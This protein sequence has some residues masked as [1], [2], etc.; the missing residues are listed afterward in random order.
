MP[1]ISS[2]LLSL[3]ALSPAAQSDAASPDFDREV[4]PILA[5][6]CFACHGPDKEGR[7]GKLR[8][9][10]REKAG[11]VSGM[12]SV[13]VA[14]DRED[15]ELWYRITTEYGDDRMPPPDHAKSLTAEEIE[16]LGKW[17][18]AG[19]PWAEHWAFVSPVKPGAPA[20]A[21]REWARDG[22]DHFVMAALERDGLKPNHEASKNKWLRRVT[23]ALTGLPPTEQELRDFL[24]DPSADA[25]GKVVDRLFASPAY[26]EHMAAA[27]LDG[28]RYADT[29]GYQ[30]DFHRAQ[31]PWRDWVVRAFN[32]NL[33]FD[34][35][36]TWQLAGDLLPNASDE[37]VLATGFGRNHRTVTEAG[38]IDEEWRV[39]NV[40]DR[41][42]TTATVFMGLTMGCARCHDHR[43]DPITQ[44]EFYQFYGFFN[45][46]DEKGV[47]QETRGNA[48]PMVRVPSAEDEKKLKRIQ[49]ELK[50]AKER[51][52]AVIAQRDDQFADW[53]DMLSK[54]SLS[55]DMAWLD[56]V[57]L[58]KNEDPRPNYGNEVFSPEHDQAFFM[59][60]WVRPR[61]DGTVIGKMDAEAAYRGIDLTLI[62]NRKISVHLIHN[63]PS[64]AVKVVSHEALEDGVW[65]HVGVSY[66]G[67]GKAAGVQLFLNGKAVGARVAADSL[68]GS[69][70]T[71]TPLRLG[72]RSTREHLRGDIHGA[73]FEFESAT[74]DK[75]G[76][77]VRADAQALW[78]ALQSKPA[79]AQVEGEKPASS[80][81]KEEDLKQIFA[82]CFHPASRES[83]NKVQQQNA[84]LA[85]FNKNIPTVMVMKDRAE[86]RPTYLLRRGLYDQPNTD[87]AL[88]TGIPAVLPGW[89]DS[90]PRNRLGLAQWMTSAENPLTARVAVNRIWQQLFGMGLVK[91]SENFG[92]QGSRPSHPQLLDWLALE[93]VESGW[94]VQALQK[95]LV[96]SATFRQSSSA[97]PENYAAD[98]GNG[99]LSRGP[100]YRLSAEQLRDQALMASGLLVQKLGGPPTRP[101]QP[102]GLW[103]EL[104]GGAGQGP[105]VQDS[106]DGLW[107]RSLYTHRK[108]SVPHPTLTTFDAPS[109]EVCMVQRPRTNTPLQALATLND[110]T[111]VHAARRLGERMMKR[112]GKDTDQLQWAFQL[113][114]CRP[115][116]EAELAIL[117]NALYA[118]LRFTPKDPAAAWTAV[119]AILLNL[120]EVLNCD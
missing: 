120:D 75:V 81:L 12:N 94:D 13:V 5:D 101:H 106:G 71:E 35:F 58:N 92:I 22:L 116:T 85:E 117:K 80:K 67:S 61:S 118:E 109:F 52:A 107:R 1:V 95:R 70:L 24:A 17:I 34:Q 7:K 6:N 98:P 46:Q 36:A 25:Y 45:S 19:A 48:G 79:V 84:A 78:R 114:T 10:Q 87:E 93:F 49:A 108:R 32:Q 50:L 4:R 30:N 76:M 102:P 33:P 99:N 72:Q 53:T 105:Y 73:R 77:H 64:N 103:T 66:D 51:H 86:P 63:W 82:S 44:K 23:L 27:W 43:Y 83:R 54:Q 40:V 41:V 69:I 39:E 31:W 91:T 42:E 119:A 26:G 28:A 47:Y 90:Y 111:Y 100:R 113:L 59:S 55:S 74:E 57:H 14:G 97:A 20:V 2:I 11:K 38:S 16:T 15:S 88:Q 21:N 29:N 9:D 96:L 37:Q 8:L 68:N 3:A 115:A 56:Y 110:P 112:G 62:E 89:K 104:A 60:A 18:D 65:S